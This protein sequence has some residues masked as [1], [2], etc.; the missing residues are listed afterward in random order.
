M[1]KK[2][3][4]YEYEESVFSIDYEKLY[5]KGFR[6]LIFDIDNTLVP[7]GADST[8]EVDEFFRY[9]QGLGFKTLLLSNNDEERTLR[10][11]KNIDSLYICDA[12]KPKPA[13]YLKAVDMLDMPKNQAVVI[14]DQIFTD[15][16]G[17][18]RSGLASI[19]VK[20]IGHDTVSK[21][22]R[23]RKL[24]NFVLHFYKR[25]KSCYMRLG[26]IHRKEA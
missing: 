18:N 11:L 24:E 15:I 17:A 9:I 1:L 19:L 25:S 8:A 16:Y 12:D 13:G 26:G 5:E 21:A 20:F 10:F 23:R 2:F 3:Y 14:G 4:P 6:G 22:G 7:H